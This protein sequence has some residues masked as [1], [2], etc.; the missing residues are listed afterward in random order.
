MS[1][2]IFNEE[3]D[4]EESVI[5]ALIEHGWESDVIRYPSE[6][7]LIRNWANILFNNNKQGTRLNDQ[8]LTSGEMAQ[9]LDQV[10][11]LQSPMALNEFINGRSISITRD[12]PN[13]PIHLGK[14][15][16]LKIYDRQE[17]ALGQSR[18]QIVQQPKFKTKSPILNSR[19]GDLMLL[20]NGMPVIHLELKRSGI[21]VS[22]AYNQ[23]EKYSHEGVFRGI[24]SLVQIFVA[25]QP[26]ESVYFANPGEKGV[27]NKAFYFHWADFNNNPINEWYTFI[28]KFLSIPMAHMLIGFYTIA[29]TDEGIL[30]VMRSYQ[31]YAAVGIANIV[32]E[33]KSHWD[34]KKQLGGHV[35]HTTGSGKTMTS[36]KAA[37]LV[38]ANHDAD[39]V[40]FL[41]DRKELG[42]QS[43][44]EY[45]S[46]ATG[47]LKR[48]RHLIIMIQLQR[49]YFH[50]MV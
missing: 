17:I 1:D 27:F 50:S 7:D 20:I 44:K 21:P 37:Q 5:K 18:Y 36:F 38:A 39:K 9:I 15:I 13:D 34:D 24:F 16:S 30:K 46:F 29:D 22:E 2:I 11:N 8:P 10:R 32:A 3:K 45:R 41:V 6:E 23:I 19:R 43:L 47:S 33:K 25:M 42:I 26:K 35:W 14:E 49:I 40:V 48:M 31:Y 28:K 12:N 4:F